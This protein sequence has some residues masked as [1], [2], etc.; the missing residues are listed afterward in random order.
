MGWK[1]A[2]T[3]RTPLTASAEPL[4]DIGEGDRNRQ[5]D[6]EIA[7]DLGGDGPAEARR[8]AAWRPGA[9]GMAIEADIG[10]VRVLERRS[11]HIGGKRRRDG[12]EF[13]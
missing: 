6:Q 10:R 1:K 9:S 12:R 4:A 11:D 5:L 13:R 3:W 2:P 8:C 7:V